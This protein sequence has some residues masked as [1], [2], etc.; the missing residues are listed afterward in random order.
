MLHK[1]HRGETFFRNTHYISPNIN[2]HNYKSH[3]LTLCFFLLGIQAYTQISHIVSTE[4]NENPTENFWELSLEE[5]MNM[6]ITT[7]G[8]KAE[9]IKDIPASVIIVT[10]KDIETY[11]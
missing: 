7:A 8:K 4:T 1:K 5:L 6:E 3:L 10:R 2:M 11:G 9:S